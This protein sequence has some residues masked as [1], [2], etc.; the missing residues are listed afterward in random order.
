MDAFGRVKE[1]VVQSPGSA[2]RRC[3]E[4]WVAF[5]DPWYFRLARRCAC[6]HRQWALRGVC[7]LS[8]REPRC[9]LVGLAR[10]QAHGGAAVERQGCAPPRCLL[11]TRSRS[12]RYMSIPSVGTCC[13]CCECFVGGGGQF[14]GVIRGMLVDLSYVTDLHIAGVLVRLCVW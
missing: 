3:G 7:V 4:G 2:V 5:W 10:G 11:R 8:C 9:V 14:L 6:V 1:Y 13:C 12:H